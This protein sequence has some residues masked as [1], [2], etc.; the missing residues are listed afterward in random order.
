MG[1][2]KGMYN[3]NKKV[4]RKIAQV[5]LLVLFLQAIGLFS[6]IGFDMNTPLISGVSGLSVFNI[7]IIFGTL[8][9]VYGLQKYKIGS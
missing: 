1:Q 6:A 4:N 3:V 7:A 2:W 8:W 5:I 9:I